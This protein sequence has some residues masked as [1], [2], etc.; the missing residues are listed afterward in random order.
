MTFIF[1]SYG[2]FKSR[3]KRTCQH[4]SHLDVV[5]LSKMP[6]SGNWNH[7]IIKL[8]IKQFITLYIN[9]YNMFNIKKKKQ[10][11]NTE[12]KSSWEKKDL[13]KWKSTCQ[14]KTKAHFE[15]WL[16]WFNKCQKRINKLIKAYYQGIWGYKI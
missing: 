1:V 11:I 16:K 9:T 13:I 12:K 4:G 8:I 14:R 5:L 2:I 6:Y 7:R 15:I 10:F 3:T